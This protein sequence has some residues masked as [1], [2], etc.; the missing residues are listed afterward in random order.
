MKNLQHAGIA[1][2]WLLLRFFA[3]DG[4]VDLFAVNGHLSWSVNAKAY[5]V[6][7]N[8]NN[9]DLDIIANYD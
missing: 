2:I 5:L 7:A 4:V 6:A 9:D 8:I 3:L 1:L